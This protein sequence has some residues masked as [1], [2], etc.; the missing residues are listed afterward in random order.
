M[1]L[2]LFQL[3]KGKK[4]FKPVNVV[5]P[6]CNS[7]DVVKNGTYSRKLIFL[8]Y[9]EQNCVIQKYKCNKCGKIIYTDLSSIVNENANITI[10]VI[11]HIEYLYSYFNGSLHKI[12]KSLKKEYNIEISH[13]SI[14]NI[15]L[16]SDYEINYENWIFSGYYLFDALWV[17]KNGKWKY[18]LALFDLKLNTIVAKELVDSETIDN[19]YNFLNKSLRNQNKN[20]IITD[21]KPEYRVAIDRLKI[22]HQFCKFHVKQL[23]NK[24]IMDYIMKNNASEKEIIII[25]DY[26]SLFFDIVDANSI[27]DAEKIRN[28]LFYLNSNI[29][30]VI[31]KL[32]SKLIIPEFK[33]THKSPH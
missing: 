32:I 17:K 33:K 26:K 25:K 6:K 31:H 11:E 12:R 14:E 15:I 21:L 5:C 8:T 4:Y 7:R 23:I 18:L 3:K 28:K 22:K 1:I 30:Q 27:K 24:Q 29:P 9:G 16:N 10:P 2:Y 13:Q 20:C 19:V